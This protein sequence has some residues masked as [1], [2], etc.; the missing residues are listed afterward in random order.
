MSLR[1]VLMRHAKSGWDDPLLEDHARVLNGR[2]RRSAEALG[3][4][5]RANNIKPDQMLISSSQRTRETCERLKLE[6]ETT[7]LEELYLASPAVMLG[8]LKRATGQCVLLLAHNPGI[9][10]LAHALVAAPPEHPRFGDY[11]TGATLIVDF[12]IENWRDLKPGTGRV[13][14]FITPR[15]IMA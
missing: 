10:M 4:W 1:L 7:V 9:A 12:E 14:D 6:A 2:G 11:P 15:E 3:V 8:V 13:A 5:L